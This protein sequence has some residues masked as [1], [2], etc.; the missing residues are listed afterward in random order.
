M[1]DHIS[2]LIADICRP[3][4]R[5]KSNEGVENLLSDSGAIDLKLTWT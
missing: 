2:W 1:I 4:G 5:I 3:R